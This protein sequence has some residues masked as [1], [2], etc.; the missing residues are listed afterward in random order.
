MPQ[1]IVEDGTGIP[2]ANSYVTL[3]EADAYL[4]NRLRTETWAEAV[5]EDQIRALIQATQALDTLVPWR[6]HKTFSEQ[7][8]GWPRL[9]VQSPDGPV[10]ESDVVPNLVKHATIE[11]ALELLRGDRLGDPEG[12]GISR[13]R[14]DV[15]DISFNSR[16]RPA[17]L[18]LMVRSMVRPLSH[19]LSTHTARV[20]RG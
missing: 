13:L 8:L 9:G 14:V 2:E 1:I 7:G 11:M 18:P 6:G 4:T 19:G 17:T 3:A 16:D 20:V 12:A 5:E 10:I 15:I